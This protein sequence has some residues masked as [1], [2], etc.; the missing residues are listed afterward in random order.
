M[1]GPLQGA[2]APA[3]LAARGV[4]RVFDGGRVPALRGVDFDVA[5]G[6][7][8]A[9]VGPSGCGKTSLLHLLGALDRPTAGEVFFRGEPLSRFR[10]LA[11]F[12][13]RRVGFVFQACHLLPT[14]TALE[15][16]EV[17]MFEREWPARR[18]RERAALLLEAVGLRDRLRHRP[19]QLSGGER[20]RAAIARSL[21]NEPDVLLADEPTGNLDSGTARRVLDLMKSIHREQGMA[22]VI[23]THDPGVAAQADRVIRMLDGRI[24]TPWNGAAA[25]S[26]DDA[27]QAR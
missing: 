21:A 2:A 11:V 25:G 18:R 16:V 10:D 5:A 6:E 15:N 8:V 20:Q 26:A 19:A 12:R 13:A 27:H 7:C 14:L 1:S 24:E 4:E 22:M 9:I 3:L 23:V 17:P